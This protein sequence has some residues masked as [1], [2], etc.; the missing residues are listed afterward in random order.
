MDILS[1]RSA[2]LK[3]AK[4]VLAIFEKSPKYFE[5]VDGAA[6]TLATVEY[7]IKNEPTVVGAKYR[8]DFLLIQQDGIAIG[9]AELH[10]AHPEEGIS[11]IALLLLTESHLGRYLG[12]R[13]Y[14]LI[15]D[16][17]RRAQ[18]TKKI[19]LG[20]S[21]EN[22]VTGFWRKM[23]FEPSGHTYAYKGEHITT[24]VVEFEKILIT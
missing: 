1:L 5:A 23:G 20:I 3:D 14:E 19:R 2:K 12:K 8:K 24:Q 16:Y 13:S 7:Y 22:D 9:A 11:Y 18:S 17:C 21:A 15:E 6:P 10:H 4:E